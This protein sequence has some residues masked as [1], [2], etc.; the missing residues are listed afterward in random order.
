MCRGATVD[1]LQ[2]DCLGSLH[3]SDVLPYLSEYQWARFD[4]VNMG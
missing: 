3:P 1:G 4:T 2:P